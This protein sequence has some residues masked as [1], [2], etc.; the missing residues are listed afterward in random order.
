MA[1][2]VSGLFGKGSVAE[3]MFV[4]GILQGVIQ[5]LLSP[6]FTGLQQDAYG[7]VPNVALSPEVAATLVNKGFLTQDQGES[8]AKNTGIS[9]AGFNQLVEIGRGVPDMSTLLTAYNRQFIQQGTEGEPGV[10]LFGGMTQSGIDAQWMPII[11]QM[12]I[13]TPSR[14]EVMNAWLEG[15]ITEDVARHWYTLAGGNPD[16]FQI[17]YNANGVA[18]SPMELGTLANRRIIPWDG[19]GPDVVSFRQGVLEGPTRN[20]WEDSWR[21]LAKY[22]PPPRSTTAMLRSGAYTETEATQRY[23]DYG[24]SADDAAAMIR[25]A[26][27]HTTT[28]VKQLTEANVVSLYADKLITEAEAVTMLVELKYSEAD[29]TYILKMADFN[30]A[31]QTTTW[32]VGRIKSLYSQRKLTSANATDALTKLHVPTGQISEL[33]TVWDIELAASPKQ[34][35]EAQVATAFSYGVID[36][37]TGEQLLIAIGYSHWDAWLLLSNANKGTIPSEPAKTVPPVGILP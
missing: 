33:L 6:V 25:D 8:I 4:Y 21:A 5:S 37:N 11:Q 17:D 32:A 18:P 15:Q 13:D 29:A 1:F 10:S 28:T 23:E 3:Q 2:D 16:W 34:L 26:R 27:P 36:Q 19:T 31:A 7:E 30:A 20:K 35:T 22:L 12:A 9:A 14:Q 24:L